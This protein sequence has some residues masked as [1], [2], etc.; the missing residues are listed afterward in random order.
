MACASD[1]YNVHPGVDHL[2]VAVEALKA[3]GV[4]D[5]DLFRL[6]VL[7]VGTR[8]FDSIHKKIAHSDQLDG[9]V[10][11]HGIVRGPGTTAAATDQA[12]FE[13]VAA[14]GMDRGGQGQPGHG[15]AGGRHLADEVSRE[16][17]LRFRNWRMVYSLQVTD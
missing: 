2:F 10:G 3:V 15:G 17:P 14:G 1:Q 12:D 8:A 6:F 16:M 13:H 7:Q 5:L 11:G 4:I 9:G